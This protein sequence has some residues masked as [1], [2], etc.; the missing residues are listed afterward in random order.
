[1]TESKQHDGETLAE[2]RDRFSDD[3]EDLFDRH[4]KSRG[5]YGWVDLLMGHALVNLFVTYCREQPRG[6]GHWWAYQTIAT[7]AV[8]ILG[9]V[10]WVVT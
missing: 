2:A 1:M 4:S 10:L 6:A 5:R 7:F 3:V 8:L 9:A